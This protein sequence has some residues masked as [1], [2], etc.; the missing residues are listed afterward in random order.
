MSRTASADTAARRTPWAIAIALGAAASLIVAVIVLAFLWPTKAMHSEN[1]P[2]AITG[3][4]AQ[5]TALETALDKAQPGLIDW[6]HVDDRDAAVDQVETRETYGAIVLDADATTMPE[7]IKATAGS[8]A[9]ANILTALASTLTTQL[10]AQATA[11]GADASGISVT[12]TDLAALNAN[13]PTGAGLV[14]AALPLVMGGMMGGALIA[15][16]VR[17]TGRKAVALV[18]YMAASGIVLSAVLGSWFGFLQGGFWVDA[19]ALALAIGATSALLVGLHSLLGPV[20]FGLG[21]IIT[22]FIGN[23]LSGASVPWQ[24]TPEP[25]GWIGQHM[26][27]G[28]SNWLIKSLSYFPETDTGWAWLTLAAWVAAGALFLLLGRYAGH[29]KRAHTRQRAA[30]SAAEPVAA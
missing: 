23:P 30:D 20:G 7:V 25:W 19:L 5:V 22:F 24:F 14:A 10:Q 16:R 28:A 4:D 1:L 18:G 29:G 2:V 9:A 12:V 6:V 27:P 26:V 15:F 3:P 21:A 17:G 11:A 8:P 13:D